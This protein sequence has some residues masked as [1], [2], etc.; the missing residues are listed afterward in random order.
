ML[1]DKFRTS[2]IIDLDKKLKTY[3]IKNYGK[4]YSHNI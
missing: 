4:R 1:I 3:I 2:Q